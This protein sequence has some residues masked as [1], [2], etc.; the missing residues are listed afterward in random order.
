MHQWNS[1]IYSLEELCLNSLPSANNFSLAN[2]A[3][4][5]FKW[6]GGIVDRLQ[7]D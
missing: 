4:K 2:N 1:L 3:C 6:K 7:G 5:H